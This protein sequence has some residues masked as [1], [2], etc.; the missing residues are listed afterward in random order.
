[1]PCCWQACSKEAVNSRR[2]ALFH[3]VLERPQIKSVMWSALRHH[4]P[5]S[6]YEGDKI[7]MENGERKAVVD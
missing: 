3:A 4:G 2:G 5:A 7:W 6:E 1:M